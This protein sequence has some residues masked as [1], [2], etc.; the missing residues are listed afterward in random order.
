MKVLILG[1]LLLLTGCASYQP[2]K[3]DFFAR[4]AEFAADRE[5]ET[6]I[7]RD[8]DQQE[9]CAHVVQVLMDMDCK[10]GEVNSELG[11][12]TALP[13]HPVSSQTI[14]LPRFYNNL[15]TCGHQVT[16]SVSG[17]GDG[18]V[19]VRSSFNPPADQADEAF[20]TL[21]RKSVSLQTTTGSA[22]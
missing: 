21:L 22:P 12:L 14:K 6:V 20:R 8:L 11:L 1:G 9:A 2:P 19:A 5:R 18:D 13:P 7:I 16:V 4:Q 3:T 17:R 10:I 15:A